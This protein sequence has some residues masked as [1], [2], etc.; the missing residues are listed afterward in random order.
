MQALVT[1]CSAFPKDASALDAS[2]SACRGSI[3]A[4]ESSLKV[5]EGSSGGWE[6]FAWACSVVVAVGVAA[7]IVGIVWEYRDD[8][9][10]WQRGIIRPPDRPSFVRF[11]W[12]EMLATV[13]VVAGIF[14]EA[15]ASREIASINSQLRSKTSELRADS[16][17]LLTLVTQEAGD[18]AGNAAKAQTKSN[19]ADLAAGDAQKKV[20]TVGEEAE[21][22]S[23]R[24]QEEATQLNDLTPRPVLLRAA[25]QDFTD[26]LLPYA[27]Q[28]VVIERCGPLSQSILVLPT[29][30]QEEQ[31]QT[32]SDIWFLL[33]D[34]S[35]ANWGTRLGTLLIWKECTG[36][37][38]VTVIDGK[39]APSTTKKAA[40]ALSDELEAVLPWNSTQYWSC[41]ACD[42][43][44]GEDE[45]SPSRLIAESENKLI[46][47][48]VGPLPLSYR[49]I[50]PTGV[51][52]P[53]TENRSR[54]KSTP[55]AKR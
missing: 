16:D 38:G 49:T 36:M 19:A 27:A 15:W 35:T 51:L 22:L 8:S 43:V 4:L 53:T 1:P 20:K 55:S 17:Q 23:A 31:T 26:K 50:A 45:Y 33:T 32:W 40:K 24:I 13:I 37:P 18:A 11:F 3:S 48:V 25:V 42:G 28:P 46:V 12:F 30:D 47:V 9:K 44:N 2:I 52:A 10:D 21:N 5:T 6:T 29:R 39:D 14:G 54:K 41:P 34:P 7:E